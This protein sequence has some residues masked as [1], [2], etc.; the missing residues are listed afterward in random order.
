MQFQDDV[1][2]GTVLVR[3]AIQS[4]DYVAGKSGWTINADGTAEFNNVTIRTTLESAN[5]VSGSAGWKLSEDGTA[6]FSQVTVHGNGSKI[7]AATFETADEGAAVVI[8][9]DGSNAIEFY[10]DSN[11]V[12]MVL[13]AGTPAQFISYNLPKVAKD[14]KIESG[15]ILFGDVASSFNPAIISAATTGELEATGHTSGTFD[16]NARTRWVPGTDHGTFFVDSPL[17]LANMNVSGSLTVGT[18]DWT[19]YTPTVGGGGSATFG[20]RTGWYYQLGDLVYVEAYITLSAAGS[21]TSPITVSLPSEPYRGT[22]QFRQ[23]VSGYGGGIA[24]GSNTSIS[25]SFC[26]LVLASGT[27]A[28]LD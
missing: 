20:I 23:V 10:D 24:A 28:M 15:Q 22:A 13:G 14:L 21:G 12:T 27:G 2:G 16:V 25:G 17:G 3:P 8:N 4:P 1:V 19:S 6:E 26:G 9:D 11:N 18:T 5:F 7:I